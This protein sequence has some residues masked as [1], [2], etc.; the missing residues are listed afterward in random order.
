MLRAL[1]Q[2]PYIMVSP[3]TSIVSIII[4]FV[5]IESIF[6]RFAA[7]QNETIIESIGADLATFVSVCAAIRTQ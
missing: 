4:I 5:S 2:F 1:C 3:V 7:S 6:I